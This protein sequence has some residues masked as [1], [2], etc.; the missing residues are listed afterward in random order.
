MSSTHK[1]AAAAARIKATESVAGAE[2]FAHMTFHAADKSGDGTLSKS[3]LRKY[4]CWCTKSGRE[5][6]PARVWSMRGGGARVGDAETQIRGSL[7]GGMVTRRSSG[8]HTP[9][10]C[11]RADRG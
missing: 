5:G 4:V 7:K 2:A 11:G 1:T 6:R 10:C 8:G 9:L 3:E